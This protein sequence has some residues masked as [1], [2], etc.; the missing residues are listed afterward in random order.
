VVPHW[1]GLDRAIQK[2]NQ[3]TE[4][5]RRRSGGLVDPQLVAD[6]VVALALDQRSNARIVVLRAGKDPYDVDPGSADPHET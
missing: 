5:E 6:T 3:M 2:F 4:D 1:I